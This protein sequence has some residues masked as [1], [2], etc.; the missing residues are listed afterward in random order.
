VN[1]IPDIRMR[2]FTALEGGVLALTYEIDH[3]GVA[4][5]AIGFYRSADRLAGGGD[6]LLSTVSVTAAGDLTA[7]VH[8]RYF[9]LG[10]GAGQVALPG[11]GSADLN[12]D[13]YLLAVAD[14]ADAVA[15][16]DDDPLKED[17]TA[18]FV[19]AYHPAGGGVYVQGTDGADRARLLTGSD[20]LVL[21]LDGGTA[22]FVAADVTS[23]RL[24]LHGGDDGLDGSGVATPLQ[25]WVGTGADTVRG[26]GGTTPSTC[27][28]APAPPP[29]WTA[30]RARTPW[31]APT[32]TACGT[33]RTR[34]RGP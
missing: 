26:G 17:N 23:F 3:G 19:G 14:P 33:S 32:R 22:N 7:S 18:V 11:V 10:T 34:T 2:S 20:V 8:T 28:P 25:G 12:T 31:W 9:P 15:E 13:Y 30:G 16:G 1:V 4:P 27:R 29:P 21:R 5:F 6:A 24:R